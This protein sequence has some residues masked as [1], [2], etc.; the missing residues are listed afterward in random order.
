MNISLDWIFSFLTGMFLIPCT[1]FDIR[2]KGIS[3]RYLI[4]AMIV[5]LATE[6]ILIIKEERS[7]TDLF[8]DIMPGIFLLLITGITKGK[9]GAG[10]GIVFLILGLMIGYFPAL[11][12]MTAALFLSGI[13]G[14]Y[15]ML[16]KKASRTLTIPWMPFVLMAY[17]VWWIAK[18]G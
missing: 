15:L 9:M 16:V 11:M 18:Q 13:Y 12:V 8:I 5:V 2:N 10:D 3:K 17:W 1:I 7:I 14:G 4:I 6:G